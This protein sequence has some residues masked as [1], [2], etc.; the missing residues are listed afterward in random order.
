MY[1]IRSYYVVALL[2][3]NGAGKTTTLRAISG[4]IGL[5]DA[6]VTQ[7]TIHFRGARIENRA[8]HR[9]TA[10]GVITSYSIHY[11]KLYELPL[12]SKMVPHFSYNFV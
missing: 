5:D 6:R 1:A 10:L 11:T 9:I 7:G 12:L 4:F 2:G 3:T 8:P